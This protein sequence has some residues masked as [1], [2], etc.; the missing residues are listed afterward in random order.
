MPLLPLEQDKAGICAELREPRASQTGGH[1]VPQ[2]STTD[3]RGSLVSEGLLVIKSWD[4][5]LLEF[6]LC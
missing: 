1:I 6:S 2:C 5:L 3:R 4:D